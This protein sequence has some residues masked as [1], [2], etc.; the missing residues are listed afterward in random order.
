MDDFKPT[1]PPVLQAI[2]T[3]TQ[4]L[5]F[6]MSSDPLT[7]SLLKT[8]AASKQGG[9]LLELG[10]GTG[11]STAWLL[12]GM[13][14]EATL[15]TVDNDSAVTEIAQKHLGHDPRL[16]IK[17]TDG[18]SLLQQ[19]QGHP[20]DFIFA[21][22]WPGKY[23]HLD[24]ALNLLKIGGIYLIDDM[25][26]QTNWSDD[27]TEKAVAL[28]EKLNSLPNFTLTQLSWSTGLALLVKTAKILPLAE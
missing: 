23:N 25:L 17:T 6:S 10:T 11:L 4:E 19:L 2:Q 24:L 28:L 21:D 26:P 5:G 18:I 27:H 9:R 12:A 8:L 14:E 3:D 7:G 16:T 13:D 20:F 22:T 15:L 1:L